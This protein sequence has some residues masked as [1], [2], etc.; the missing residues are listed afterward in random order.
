MCLSCVEDVDIGAV[1]ASSTNSSS[2]SG[3]AS[4]ASSRSGSTPSS[5]SRQASS[6]GLDCSSGDPRR[7]CNGTSTGGDCALL[8]QNC[9]SG[10]RCYPA[11]D[12]ADVGTCY[13]AGPRRSGEF[14]QEPPVDTPES[15][16]AGF[17]CTYADE[18]STWGYCL[19]MCVTDDDCV[20]ARRCRH[21]MGD[22][23]PTT[24]W[25]ACMD[26][27][28]LPLGCNVHTQNCVG[29]GETCAARH[30]QPSA[31]VM[32]GTGAL[33][34]VCT[35]Q[36]ACGVGL[37]CARQVGLAA[38]LPLFT[39]DPAQLASGGNCWSRCNP[40]IANTCGAGQGCRAI[41]LENG[42]T[43]PDVGVCTPDT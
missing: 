1:A 21:F 8:A 3:M 12:T 27:V 39:V 38:G 32:P 19:A 40:D 35:A 10:Q 13:P 29:A 17:F 23:M 34:Q 25:G 18:Q 31:C 14:C 26:D 15:C 4:S 36:S 9:P 37:Q 24:E 41:L 42:T 33:A 11:A 20:L 16:G 22:T 5:S 2:S 6:S 30:D 28:P 7:E 43:R